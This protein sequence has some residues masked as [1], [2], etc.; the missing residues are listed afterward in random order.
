MALSLSDPFCVER[1]GEAFRRLLGNEVDVLFANEVEITL[2]LDVPDVGAAAQLIRPLGILA[3]LTMGPDGSLVVQGHETARVEAHPVD[4]VVDVTGAGDLYAAGFLHGLTHGA[5]LATCA[6]LAS[7]AAS[8]I[9]SHLGAR[10]EVAL[11]P[12]AEEAGLLP[13]KG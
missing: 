5:Q 1:H 7:L 12:L 8:E 4:K 9:I 13:A 10:P 2:L 6:R 3:A 11:R